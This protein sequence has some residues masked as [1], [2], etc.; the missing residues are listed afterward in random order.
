[1][2]H[3]DPLDYDNLFPGTVVFENYRILRCVG[4]GSTSV[5]YACCMSD[6]YELVAALK[7][8]SRNAGKDEKIVARFRSEQ[9][10]ANRVKHPNVIHYID[11]LRNS[12]AEAFIIELAEGGSLHDLM[13]SKGVLEIEQAVRILSQLCLGLQA[14]HNAGIVHRDL[15]PKNILMT[16]RHD[17]KISDFSTALCPDAGRLPYD[18]GRVGT[19]E[20][21]SPE[22]LTKGVADVR[23]DIFALGIIAYQM[24]T[25]ELPFKSI[26][27][28]SHRE[29]RRKGKPKPLHSLRPECPKSLSKVI[30]RALETKPAKRFQSAKNLYEALQQ[31]NLKAKAPAS[32][33]L[34]RIFLGK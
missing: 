16:L 6:E 32:R 11:F 31:I 17:V 27:F 19:Y 23:S 4:K 21:M 30:M 18:V 5:V 3:P 1:M 13:F 14:L 34:F 25:G 15:K 7:V 20:Y 8:L 26:S 9:V 12:H 10:V 29:P 2:T 28:A 33:R 22:V 24:I